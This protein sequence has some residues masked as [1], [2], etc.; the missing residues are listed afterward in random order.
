KYVHSEGDANWWTQQGEIIFPADAKS[1][2]YTPAGVRDVYGNESF[3]E[4]D[5]YFLAPKKAIDAI[6]NTVS[7]VCDYRTLSS[8]M[9]TDANF[10]RSAVETDELGMVIKMAVMGKE[11]A[12]EGDTLADPTSRL[13]YDLHNYKNSGKPNYA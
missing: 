12:G 9:V 13:E 6:G 2:F 8:V 7:A 11:G 1:K 5:K 4:Y 10:N 3:V